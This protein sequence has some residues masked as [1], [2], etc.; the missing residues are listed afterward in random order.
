MAHWRKYRVDVR[1][2]DGA[3]PGLGSQSVLVDGRI[4]GGIIHINRGG[5]P[6]RTLEEAAD[7]EL[8]HIQENRIRFPKGEQ[9][10]NQ[11]KSLSAGLE[12][13][14][15]A[16]ERWRMLQGRWLLSQRADGSGSR[17]DEGG[18]RNHFQIG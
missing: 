12:R 13:S 9:N 18:L 2:D 4:H 15:L 3:I 6:L 11:R 5:P 10:D 17:P 1:S 8:T 7:D 16:L 14:R